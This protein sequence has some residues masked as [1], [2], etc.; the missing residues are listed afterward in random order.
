MV[1]ERIEP[2]LVDSMKEDNKN[3]SNLMDPLRWIKFIKDTQNTED[4]RSLNEMFE[5]LIKG[6]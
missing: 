3:L 4:K 2:D 6:R 1:E 5:E